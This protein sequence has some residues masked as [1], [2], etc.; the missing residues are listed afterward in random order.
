MEEFFE[1]EWTR[2]FFG[3]V[4]DDLREECAAHGRDLAFRLFE[5]YDLEDDGARTTYRDLAAELGVKVTDVT[6][7]LSHARRQFRRIALARL[8]EITASDEEW[9]EEARALLG[10]DPS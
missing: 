6:N 10:I 9:R 2:S 4:V 7:H 8:R 1:R 3:L 5:R